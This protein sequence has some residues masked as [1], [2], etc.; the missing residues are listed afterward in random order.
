VSG[1]ELTVATLNLENG[2]ELELLP[3]LVSQVTGIDILLLQEAR[4]FDLNG[5]E[6][7]FRAEELLTPLGLDRGFLTRSTRG[8]LHEMVLAR[9]P[10]V[11]PVAHFTLDLPDVFHDQAGWLRVR[12]SGLEPVLSL[13]SVQWAHWNGDVRLDEAQKLTR[14]A[15][16][17]QA[18]II[19]GDFNS[20]WPGCTDHEP[21]FEP[22]WAMLP[23]HKQHHKTLPP[24]LRPGGR[25]V[26]DR[27]ALTILAQ[28]GFISAGCAA[29]DVTVTVNP[30]IDHGQGAR[31]DHVVVSPLLAP[32]ILP[33]SYRVWDGDLAERAS[34]HRMVSVRLDLDRLG[35]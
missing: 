7:R 18:A 10:R 8:Q 31:I 5:Q 27:R 3:R 19:A 24:G 20:L 29:K 32:A 25:L 1:A 22:D 30:G 9:S 23:P 16:P 35:R 4:G 34:D 26:S 13:R 6:L 15:A 33:G 21:E 14:Y 2:R 28:A 12:V 17:G 11:R